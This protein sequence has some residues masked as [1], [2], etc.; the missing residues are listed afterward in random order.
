MQP[1]EGAN[2]SDI[3][4]FGAMQL[5]RDFLDSQLSRPVPAGR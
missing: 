2:H 3:Y 1:V 5:L 4:A